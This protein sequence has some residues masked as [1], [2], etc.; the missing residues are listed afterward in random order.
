MCKDFKTC[1]SELHFLCVCLQVT[2][3]SRCLRLWWESTATRW[4]SVGGTH[5]TCPSSHPLLTARSHSG[6]TTHNTHTN[7]HT[8]TEPTCR[9][10][11]K[12]THSPK[13]TLLLLH[14][15]HCH[16]LSTHLTLTSLKTHTHTQNTHLHLHTNRWMSLLLLSVGNQMDTNLWTSKAHMLHVL[17]FFTLHSSHR[18]SARSRRGSFIIVTPSSLHPLHAVSSFILTTQ[19]KPVSCCMSFFTEESFRFDRTELFCSWWCLPSVSITKMLKQ[20]KKKW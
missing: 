6:R 15:P 17:L 16:V 12:D 5:K 11:L 14:Y 13:T 20:T 1:L 4:S 9:Y 10:N 19:H 7:T 18:L 8:Y 2:W 3:P